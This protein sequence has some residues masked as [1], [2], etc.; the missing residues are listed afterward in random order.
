MGRSAAT[1]ARLE[2][3]HRAI[4]LAEALLRAAR[5]GQTPEERTRAERLARLME[6]PR[7]KELTIALTDQ[8]F[9]SRRPA[10]SRSCRISS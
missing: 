8:V 5:A 7:G 9:R 2:R 6:D 3:A 4:D 1:V 10:R